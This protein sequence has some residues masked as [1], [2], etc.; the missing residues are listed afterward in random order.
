MHQHLNYR[1][2]RGREK[3]KGTEKIFLRNYSLKLPQHGKG[4]SQSSPLQDKS[5]EK[6]IEAHINQA[7]R[8]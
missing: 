6:H 1:G 8:D 7:N 2:L 4:N 5:K 3:K